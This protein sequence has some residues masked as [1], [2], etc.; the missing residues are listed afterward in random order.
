[1]LQ[2]LLKAQV[3]PCLFAWNCFHTHLKSIILPIFEPSLSLSLKGT[4]F[5]KRREYRYEISWK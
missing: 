4:F 5:S 1:M 2:L 3:S